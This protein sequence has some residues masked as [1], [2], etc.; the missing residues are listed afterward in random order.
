ATKGAQAVKV[1]KR[2][3]AWSTEEVWQNQKLG[4]HID[5]PVSDGD[6]QFGLSRER[7]GQ[8]F[9][10]SARTGAPLWVTVGREGEQ[11]SI[12]IAGSALFYFKNDGELIVTR[13]SDKGFDPVA[14]YQV[15]DTPV[16]A[17]PAIWNN[18]IL[19]KDASALT[20]WSLE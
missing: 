18:Q 13:K 6:L 15:A 9:C 2:G 14:R 7:K 19:T 8:F 4:M 17:H 20:L 1:L 5:S 12:L 3:D 10:L 11:A 16:W